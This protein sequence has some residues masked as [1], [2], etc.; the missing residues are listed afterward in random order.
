MS[1][2][3]QKVSM[4]NNGAFL[5]KFKVNIGKFSTDFTGNYAA[6]QTRTIDL[7]TEIFKPGASMTVTGKA[8]AGVTRHFSGLTY[9]GDGKTIQLVCSGTT[10]NWKI[11]LVKVSSDGS[12]EVQV[13]EYEEVE[14]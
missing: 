13:L 4:L 2:I 3:G 1:A 7:G 12:E 5:V 14:S 9:A 11:A 6:G 10:Q 8:E